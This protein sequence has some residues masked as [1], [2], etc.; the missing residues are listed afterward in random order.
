M[1]PV[2]SAPVTTPQPDQQE[3]V[4]ALVLRRLGELRM[5]QRE[6]ATTTGIPYSTLNAWVTRRR[7]GGGGIDPDHLRA[8][9]KALKITAAEM[10][11]AN[12]RQTPGDLDEVR[13][14]KLLRLYRNLSVSGQRALIQTAETLSKGMRAS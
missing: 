7:G 10:F 6:L 13:E 5:S 11:A 8:L 2:D 14:A 9:A 4:A 3:D 1:R 12:G